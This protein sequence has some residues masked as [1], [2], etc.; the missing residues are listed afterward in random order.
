VFDL[1]VLLGSG[2]DEVGFESTIVLET[3][4]VFQL[5]SCRVLV[6][7]IHFDV[8]LGPGVRSREE[9]MEFFSVG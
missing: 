4:G 3:A 5:S 7:L 9:G 8:R 6:L 2:L 1:D